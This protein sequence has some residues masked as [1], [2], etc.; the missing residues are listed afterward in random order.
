[1]KS[2]TLA[3]LCIASLFLFAFSLLSFNKAGSEEPATMKGMVDRH[4]YWRKKVKVGPV[5][6]SSTLASVAQE[7]ANELARRGCEMKHRPT[8]GR[9]DGSAFGENIYWSSGLRN[10]AASVVDSWASEIKFFNS[11]N[12][13]CK[14]GVCG[15][16][17]QV[18]WRKTTEIG[19][20]MAKCG[21]Q[22]IWVCNYSPPGNYVG[23]KPY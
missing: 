7:W 18:V 15:H 4:N 2:N 22:E 13:K 10:E 21:N 3:K 8:G 6:W 9:W 11:K 12:G 23:Q 17:T 19:C 5:S 1:M 20:G 14:G 16:Y